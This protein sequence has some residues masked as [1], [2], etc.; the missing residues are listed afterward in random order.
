MNSRPQKEM[1]MDR[2]NSD[3]FSNTRKPA[4]ILPSQLKLKRFA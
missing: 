1:M 4:N 3:A 2:F